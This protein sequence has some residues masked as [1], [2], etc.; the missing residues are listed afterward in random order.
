MTTGLDGHYTSV[1]PR[2]YLAVFALVE[3][4]VDLLWHMNCRST[5]DIEGG[6]R[7]TIQTP[8]LDALAFSDASPNG[9]VILPFKECDHK[10]IKIIID[11]QK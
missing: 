4:P 1:P 10:Y 3:R 2:R 6:A 7:S 8:N 11:I 5:N 9:T